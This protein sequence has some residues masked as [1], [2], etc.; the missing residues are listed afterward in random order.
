MIMKQ[1]LAVLGL[2]VAST[3]LYALDC[4]NLG[5]RITNMSTQNCTLKHVN[6]SNGLFLSPAPLNL[7]SGATSPIFY[8]QQ[9]E[10]GISVELDY[11]CDDNNMVVINSSQ[12]YCAIMAGYVDGWAY[13]GNDLVTEHQ[14]FTGSYWNATPGQINW[15]IH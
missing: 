3:G 13:N 14:E 15:T 10:F 7:P 11:R 9:N 4:G 6:L 8:L 5:I 12:T 1:Y 2:A